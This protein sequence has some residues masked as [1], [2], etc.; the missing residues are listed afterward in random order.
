MTRRDPLELTEAQFLRQLVDLAA[1]LGWHYVHFRPA[2]TSRG[3]R[4]PVQGPLGKGWPD[5]TL[6]RERDR[7]LVFVELKSATGKLEPEQE[8]VLS[9]LRAAGCETYVWRPADL[10]EAYRVLDSTPTPRSAAESVPL[11]RPSSGAPDL[12]G[13]DAPASPGPSIVPRAGRGQ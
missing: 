10:D 9:I 3:W 7:R 11:A 6:V 2:Q 4:T 12:P 5:V 13:G 8:R 1:I